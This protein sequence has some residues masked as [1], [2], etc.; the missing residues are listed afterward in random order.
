MSEI[1]P[2]PSIYLPLLM[3]GSLSYWQK[4]AN[5]ESIIFEQ[6]EHFPRQTHRNR[7]DI[8]AANG[9]QT[10]SAPILWKHGEKQLYPTVNF[11]DS[12]PWRKKHLTALKSAYGKSPFYFLVEPELEALYLDKSLTKV[13][14]FNLAAFKFVNSILKLPIEIEFTE[15]FGDFK[16]ETLNFYPQFYDK[17][18]PS[19]EPEISYW[20]TF[21]EKTGFVPNLS[22]LDLIFNHGAE[23]R[24]NLLKRETT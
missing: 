24:L 4:I 11:N 20:Q 10:L 15:S 6:F 17:K 8:T 21:E 23:A 7:F 3:F 1:K 22:I 19:C 13:W 16:E 14:E 12:E 5:A 18:I 9:K 2:S